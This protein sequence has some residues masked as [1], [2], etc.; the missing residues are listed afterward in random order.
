MTPIE[1]LV[2]LFFDIRQKR[3]LCDPEKLEE[4]IVEEIKKTD[5]SYYEEFNHDYKNCGDGQ[6]LLDFYLQVWFSKLDNRGV[7]LRSLKKCLFE[8]V[9]QGEFFNIYRN[10][11]TVRGTF[12][13]GVRQGKFTEIRPEGVIIHGLFVNGVRE[14][15]FSESRPDIT[16]LLGTYIC[17]KKQGDFVESHIDGTTIEGTYV[18]GIKQGGIPPDKEI[19]QGVYDCRGKKLEIMFDNE[20]GH[21]VET[22]PDGT[23]IKGSVDRNGIKQGDFMIKQ[24]NGVLQEGIFV[25]GIVQGTLIISNPENESRTELTYLNGNNHGIRMEYRK[26][27][28]VVGTRNV[29]GT[30]QGDWIQV[31]PDGTTIKGKFVNGIIQDSLIIIKKL[32]DGRTIEENFV[33][34][35][36]QGDYIETFPDGSMVKGKYV[37][38]IKQEDHIATF[39]DGKIIKVKVVDGIQYFVMMTKQGQVIRGIMVNGKA[40]GRFIETFPN[41]SIYEGIFVQGKMT[42]RKKVRIDASFPDLSVSP[43]SLDELLELLQEKK[44]QRRKRLQNAIATQQQLDSQRRKVYDFFIEL[45]EIQISRYLEGQNHLVIGVLQTDGQSFRYYGFNVRQ[46]SRTNNERSRNIRFAAEINILIPRKIIV[47]L[48]KEERR[49]LIYVER[50]PQS[51]IYDVI[52]SRSVGE[53]DFDADI[54]PLPQPPPHQE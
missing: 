17:G 30:L 31:S 3:L 41:G 1:S 22:N 50:D 6:A 21:F 47:P 37:N 51:D 48:I 35:I 43:L 14:G 38:G 40:K 32:A 54:F 45:E 26:D 24:P 34:G 11:V 36:N 10:G 23:I 12:V 28:T 39:P 7:D 4:R 13:N 49:N 27:G 42:E 2:E 33:N 25:N 16:K 15:K 53:V 19:K 20:Q 46:V 5:E 52:G 29:L 44:T 18:D 9:L 8:I